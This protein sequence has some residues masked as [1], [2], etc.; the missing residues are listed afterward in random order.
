M[1]RWACL[2]LSGQFS[3][4]NQR[5]IL[6]IIRKEVNPHTPVKLSLRSSLQSGSDHEI[7]V[8]SKVPKGSEDSKK[9]I[10]RVILFRTSSA[11]FAYCIYNNN[12]YCMHGSSCYYS[13][14]VVCIVTLL[15]SMHTT[16]S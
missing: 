2:I 8:W 9:R 15:A 7:V 5:T 12:A 3:V 11:T 14:V 16:S 4:I 6:Y 13:R 1:V 10:R